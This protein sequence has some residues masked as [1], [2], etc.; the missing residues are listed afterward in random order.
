MTTEY[1]FGV[2]A[3]LIGLGALYLGFRQL[4]ATRRVI[5]YEMAA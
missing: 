4:R 1:L 2:I 5:V 3:T